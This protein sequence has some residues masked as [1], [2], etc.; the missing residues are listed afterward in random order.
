MKKIYGISHET[1]SDESVNVLP[2]QYD[3]M[4]YGHGHTHKQQIGN[5]GA[6]TRA[7]KSCSHAASMG[8]ENMIIRKQFAVSPPI[9]APS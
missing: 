6:W 8:S 5:F 2:N 7:E 4:T 9:L 3:F 1:T